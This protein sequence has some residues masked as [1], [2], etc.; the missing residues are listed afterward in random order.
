VDGTLA[1]ILPLH[2]TSILF[3]LGGGHSPLY[4]LNVIVWDDALGREVAE[5]EL[6]ERV[7]GMVCRR[8]WLIVS[9]RRRVIM[10]LSVS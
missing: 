8:G 7:R 5:L 1:M 3:L 4:P 6:R 2:T 10:P 9:L